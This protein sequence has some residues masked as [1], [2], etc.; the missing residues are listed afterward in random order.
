[1]TRSGLARPTAA[2]ALTSRPAD[3]GAPDSAPV[4]TAVVTPIGPYLPLL[5]SSLLGYATSVLLARGEVD[6]ID[7]CM[8]AH[9][10]NRQLVGM[11]LRN[12][13]QTADDVPVIMMW[14]L[15]AAQARAE[16]RKVQWSDY[17]QVFVTHPGWAPTLPAGL[18]VELAEEI[19]AQSPNTEVCCFGT[20]LGTWTDV[21]ALAHG[22]VRPV[23]LNALLAE[24]PWARPIDYDQLPAPTF[25]ELEGYIFRLLPFR[26][27]HGCCWGRCRFCSISRGAG[28]GYQER[29]VEHVAAELARMV[30]TYAPTGLV[31][32]DNAVNGGR[33]LAFCERIGQLGKPWLCAAR[34]DLSRTEVLALA[35]SGCKGVYLGIESGNEQ[36]LTAMAKGTTVQEHDQVL[37]WLPEAGIEPVPSVF[38]G[39]PWET[40]A[41]FADTCALL[42][43]HR[44]RVHIVNVYKFRWSPGT[45]DPAAG[46]PPHANTERR[47]DT[48]LQ[49]C[50]ENGM[51]PVP[52]I[53]TLEFL[54]ARLICPKTQG[55]SA[56]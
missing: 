12:L 51:L 52:G 43:R 3:V 16:Y 22:R 42:R 14:S 37:A 45:G 29:S 36:V 10:A 26:L 20:S 33:L 8:R 9:A 28:A 5:P 32:H 35:R 11:A 53:T 4:K 54:F 40:E 15:L 49:V 13:E 50:R 27:R 44:G 39:A 48:L 1:M 24:S 46:Q 38:V 41:A 56:S 6:V 19:H 23:H 17:E 55:Y 31:C 25:R 2:D 34:S 7:F 47:Y 18:I 21:D 30:E